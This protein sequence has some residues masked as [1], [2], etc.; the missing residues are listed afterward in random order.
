MNESKD[1]IKIIFTTSIVGI[2]VN[3]VLAAFKAIIG[4]ISNSIA[5]VLDGVN[6][7]A[8][9]T[10]SLITIIGAAL[11]GKPADRKHPFGYG[12]IEYL[13]ALIISVIVTYAG[14][15]AF[16]E[17]VKKIIHPEE[18]DYS[19][20]SIIILIV[21]VIA[22]FL[23]A[24]YTKAQGK[25]ANSDSLIASGSEALLDVTVSVATI[26]AAVIFIFTRVNLEPY[27]AAGIAII[28][29]KTG[30]DLLI[31][32]ISKILGEPLELS[33]VLDIKK[34][35][36]TFEGVRGAYDLVTNNY[37]PDLFTASVHIEVDENLKA[38]E[39][40]TLSRK[41][42]DHIYEKYGIYLVAVGVYS[43]NTS[44]VKARE[45]EE[46]IIKK[47]FEQQY[48]KG[49]HGFYMNEEE[50]KISFDLVISLDS[51]DRRQSHTD[52]VDAIKADYPGYIFDVGLDTD[53][54]EV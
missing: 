43:K 24:T 4:I 21:A 34:E 44:D 11:A 39:I 8:D 48:V 42:S 45:I 36:K 19:T 13:S 47:A 31:E 37:G 52:A 35:I 46:A 17:S 1:R 28:I 6:N 53:L 20:V 2:V 5:I 3:V 23:L 27:L 41:I 18:A 16:V 29:V 30:V 26:V 15:T 38:S 33:M 32:T 25:K 7:L 49:I 14:I 40:D 50:K 9:A 22:K 10:S 54:N 12:R 51:K